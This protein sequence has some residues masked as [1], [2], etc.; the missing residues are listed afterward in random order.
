MYFLIDLELER[1][2]FSRAKKLKEDFVLICDKMCEKLKSIEN[3]L[4]AFEKTKS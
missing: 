2:N 1:S 4:K 3:R